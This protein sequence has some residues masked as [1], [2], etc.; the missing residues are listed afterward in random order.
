M[1]E[2]PIF[3]IGVTIMLINAAYDIC[4]RGWII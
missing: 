3:G 4:R 2:I 1:P